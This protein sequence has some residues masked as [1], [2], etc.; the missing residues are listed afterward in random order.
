MGA[1]PRLA[2]SPRSCRLVGTSGSDANALKNFIWCD[3]LC[4]SSVNGGEEWTLLSQVALV[5][6]RLHLS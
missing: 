3:F 6:D 5:D 1:L 4:H 2:G